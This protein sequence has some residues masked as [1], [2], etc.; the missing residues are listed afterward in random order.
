M[1]ITKMPPIEF[2]NA[3]FEYRDGELI[4]KHRDFAPKH[5]NT[6]YAGKPAGVFGPSGYKA[7]SIKYCGKQ[8]K[9]LVHRVIYYMHNPEF[10]QSNYIDHID[11][12]RNNNR[13]ENLR[14]V[15]NSEN[16]KN[17]EAHKN[18]KSG[19]KNIFKIGKKRKP[20]VV[21]I[22]IQQYKRFHVGSFATLAEA[23]EARDF[24][25]QEAGYVR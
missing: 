14:A 3:C 8:V 2:I 18:S 1:K 6:R 12:S 10:D 13:I 11:Y 24:F 7:V 20:W 22:S 23:I 4:W 5:I 25:Q 16:M 19:Y 9:L 21:Q 17:K 15:S